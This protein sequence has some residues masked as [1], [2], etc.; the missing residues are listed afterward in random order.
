MPL[1]VLIVAV[2]VATGVLARA[3]SREAPDELVVGATSTFSAESSDPVDAILPPSPQPTSEVLPGQWTKLPAAPT[4]GRTRHT[5]TWTGSEMLIYGG[6]PDPGPATGVRFDLVTGGWQLMAS[7]PMGSRSGHTAVWTGQ[8][9]IVFEGAPIG[10][11]AA[12]SAQ[13]IDGAAYDPASDTWRVI[14]DAPVNPRSGHVAVWTGSEMLVFGGS[15]VFEHHAPAALYNPDTDSWRLSG[16]S[17]LD[18]AF[19]RVAAVWTG[20][21]VLIWSGTGEEDVAAYDPA[22][23]TWR[24]LP[25]S[26]IGMRSVSAVWTGSEMLLLGLPQGNRS[27]I[28]GAA[29][30]L[31]EARW[32]VLPPS[33]QAFAATFATLWTGTEAVVV[34]GP[35]E[36]LGAAWNPDLGRWRELPVG[37]QSALSGHAAVWTGSQVLLWGG[38]D[39]VGPLET[40]IAFTPVG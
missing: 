8:E 11:S 38:Q 21:E 29:L 26:P 2:V 37:P 40:G 17:P 33:P 19:G 23:D 30:N 6:Q 20:E 35:A 15:R 39:E 3:G 16:A 1:L 36:D 18:R 32:T 7:S 13:E 24:S 27:Q 12:A 5:A 34:G 28:G 25:G 14:A 9:L 10:Q 4:P 22:A 31:A